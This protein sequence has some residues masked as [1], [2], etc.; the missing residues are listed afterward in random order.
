VRWILAPGAGDIS[1]A[2]VRTAIRPS[3]ALTA[4]Q[5]HAEQAKDGELVSYATEIRL[6]AERRAGELL[7]D[8]AERGERTASKDTLA[9]GRDAQPREAPTLS[10][11]GVSKSQSSRWQQ[12]AAMPT[13]AFEAKVERAKEIAVSSVDRPSPDEKKEH[14]ADLRAGLALRKRSAFP[15]SSWS[16]PDPSR[17]LTLPEY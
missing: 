13:K 2:L 16:I 6:R 10:D 4:M 3:D 9:R 12:L 5:A 8:M 1:S 17:G 15:R 7:I 14:R 11:L